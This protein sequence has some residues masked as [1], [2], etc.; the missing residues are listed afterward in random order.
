[1][2]VDAPQ[3]FNGASREAARIG[4]GFGCALAIS[5]SW[6]TNK[7]LF[8]VLVHGFLSWFYV[9]YFVFTHDEWT[10]F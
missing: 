9:I 10:W 2:N 4:I 8:W 1:M 7:S 3:K 6:A 5:I